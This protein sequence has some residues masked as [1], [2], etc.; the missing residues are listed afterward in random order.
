VIRGERAVETMTARELLADLE[1]SFGDVRLNGGVSLHQARAFDNYE[2]EEVAQASR[3]LDMERRW[4]DISDEKIERFADTLPFMDAAGMQFHLP[5]LMRWAIEHADSESP[6]YAVDAVVYQCRKPREE[7]FESF[8]E[9]QRRTVARFLAFA[10]ARPD[11]FD[12]KPATR[13]LAGPWRRWHESTPR[14]D[15]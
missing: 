2:P 10:A 11:A 14:A 3:R 13:A 7:Q 1:Q 8:S 9:A 6:S 12:A 15:V 4:Q 5:R